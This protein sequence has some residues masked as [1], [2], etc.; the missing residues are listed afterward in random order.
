MVKLRRRSRFL[1]LI[2]GINFLLNTFVITLFF[3]HSS[4]I[5]SKP[6]II[7]PRSETCNTEVISTIERSARALGKLKNLLAGVMSSND[8]P[9]IWLPTDEYPSV[10]YQPTLL[11]N[12]TI[13][14][15]LLYNITQ[16]PKSVVNEIT[17]VCKR[18]RRADRVGGK[19]WCKLFR[20]SYPNTLATT[21]ALLGDNSTYIITGDIDLMW[22]RDSR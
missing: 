6:L 22:L 20:T 14:K 8:Q 17:R 19:I 16:L 12:E 5:E 13:P 15:L 11:S 7:S 1:Y 4:P 21:T 9:W 18:L 2:I 10:P 3:P